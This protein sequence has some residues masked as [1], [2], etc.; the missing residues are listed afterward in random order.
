MSFSQALP[1]ELLMVDASRLHE[2]AIWGHPGTSEPGRTAGGLL[3]SRQ[4]SQLRCLS[5]Q[6][7]VWQ[8]RNF[9]A[10]NS[11][12]EYKRVTFR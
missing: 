4:N 6:L 1:H 8:P 11:G 2:D 12:R 10:L 5:V 9:S 3:H 7:S